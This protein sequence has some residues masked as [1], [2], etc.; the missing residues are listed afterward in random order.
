MIYFLLLNETMKKNGSKHGHESTIY[1]TDFDELG[2]VWKLWSSALKRRYIRQNPL[3][4]RSIYWGLENFAHFRPISKMLKI[5]KNAP[6][7]IQ[8]CAEIKT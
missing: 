2:A 8:K 5:A 7:I 3:G 6:K 4:I 1:L